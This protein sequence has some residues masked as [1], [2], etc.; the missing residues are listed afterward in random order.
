[1]M[2]N[3]N[4]VI[5]FHEY[6]RPEAIPHAERPVSTLTVMRNFVRS[7]PAAVIATCAALVAATTLVLFTVS[8]TRSRS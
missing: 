4:P 2:D 5:Q 8:G 7:N 6:R 1:M 3:L